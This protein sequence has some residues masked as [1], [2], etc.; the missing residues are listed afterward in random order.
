MFNYL[1]ML[2]VLVSVFPYE[3]A[4]KLCGGALPSYIPE[5]SSSG[6]VLLLRKFVLLVL[7]YTH[8]T[9]WIVHVC[10]DDFSVV[11]IPF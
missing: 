3:E 4:A 7:M 10:L 5:V 2:Q 1:L 6:Y 9:S 8:P 11:N